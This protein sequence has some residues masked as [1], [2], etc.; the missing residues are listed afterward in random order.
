MPASG[1][2][3][4]AHRVFEVGR[5]PEERTIRVFLWCSQPESSVSTATAS[6]S[7]FEK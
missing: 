6:T 2:M 4:T 5:R 7:R 1:R 3:R